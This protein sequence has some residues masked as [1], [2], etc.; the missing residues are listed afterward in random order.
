[1]RPEIR[2]RLL[3]PTTV[4]VYVEGE[5]TGSG[6]FVGPGTVVTCKHV[7]QSIDFDQAGA[8]GLIRIE[9]LN[10][11][12]YV[13]RQVR[14]VSPNKVEDLAVLR[15]DPA[16]GHPC[17]LLDQGL[18]PGDDIHTFGYTALHNEGIPLSLENE[19]LAG[20][21]LLFKLK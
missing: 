17:V 21:K 5:R 1:S 14:H 18:N 15:V 16:N 8:V 9:G 10:G 6:F 12:P 20:D 13:V 3:P 19:G 7:L 4:R 11:E 2:E